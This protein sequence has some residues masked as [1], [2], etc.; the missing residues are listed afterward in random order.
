[1]RIRS[2]FYNKKKRDYLPATPQSTVRFGDG[3]SKSNQLVQECNSSNKCYRSKTGALGLLKVLASLALACSTAASA[4]NLLYAPSQAAERNVLSHFD[5]PLLSRKPPSNMKEESTA[6]T[7]NTCSVYL[8]PASIPGGGIGFYT[9]KAVEK[10]GLIHPA[11]C[12][13]IPLIDPDYSQRSK[14]AW[15]QLWSGYWWG[16]GSSDATHFEAWE[17]VDFQSGIGAFPNTHSYLSNVAMGFS[18]IVPI[19]DSILDRSVSP[20][21]GASSYNLGRHAIATR[22]IEEGEEIFLLYPKG[23]LDRLSAKYN[24]PKKDDFE[25]AGK[26]IS[27]LLELFQGNDIPW[28]QV[29]RVPLFGRVSDTID[30]LLPHSQSNLD[31]ILKSSDN[32]NSPSDL[33]LAVAKE[34]SVNKRSVKWIQE[35]GYC[36]DNIVMDK[37]LNAHAGKG[38]FAQRPIKKKEVIVPA[39]LLQINDRDALRMP[40][41]EGDKMQ[42]LLNYCFGHGES[43]LLLCPYSNAALLNHCSARRP[44]LH[45]CGHDVK[46]NAKYRWSKWDKETATWLEKS[47]EDIQKVDGR[48]PL[49]LEI[50]ATR[51]IEQGEELFL[52]YGEKWEVAWDQHLHDWLP[53]KDESLGNEIGKW[54]SA[55]QRNDELLPLT[56]APDFSKEFLSMDSRGILFTGC[57]YWVDETIDWDQLEQEKPWENM[58]VPDIIAKFAWPADHNFDIR[59]FPYPSYTDGKFWPCVVTK[60]KGEERNEKDT[61]TVRFVQSHFQK[62]AVWEEKGLPLIFTG[63]PRESIRHFYLPYK[64]D[65]HLQNAFRH[66]IDFRDEIFPEQWRDRK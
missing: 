35:N 58:T 39:P 4:V 16:S 41:F 45:P 21:A 27:Y 54:K 6:D 8:A 38:A 30:S 40:A 59:D 64:S 34:M 18:K 7:S 25:Q 3:G 66:H 14:D 52:D 20:G 42:L 48:V 57:L 62:K 31:K 1:M 32:S 15:V 49:S 60:P 61:Y 28:N 56:P 36:M 44:D 5:D 17:S 19:D 13:A 46:P 2:R 11:D 51:N 29:F 23:E 50:V 53:A 24:V 47:L 26:W 65:Q 12:P 22:D 43:S 63:Y 9:T 10:G 55:R 37:S 33:S